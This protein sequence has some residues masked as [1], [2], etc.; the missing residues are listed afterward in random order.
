MHTRLTT[1][2]TKNTLDPIFASP[3][4]KNCVTTMD[5]IDP[6]EAAKLR[7]RAR[8]LVGNI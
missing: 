1:I 8:K 6:P 4:G 5:P 2:K 7:P 3:T